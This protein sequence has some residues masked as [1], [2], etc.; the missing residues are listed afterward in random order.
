MN[1]YHI[2]SLRSS[3]LDDFGGLSFELSSLFVIDSRDGEVECR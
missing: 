1:N 2:H 3:F